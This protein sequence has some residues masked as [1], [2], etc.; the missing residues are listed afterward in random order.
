MQQM[1]MKQMFNLARAG[2]H[3]KAKAMTDAYTRPGKLKE[4]LQLQV[5]LKNS[6]V[7]DLVITGKFDDATRSA[8]DRCL[9]DLTCVDSIDRRSL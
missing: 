3:G 4:I 5:R 9:R 1:R 7:P 6:S 8:L 2:E